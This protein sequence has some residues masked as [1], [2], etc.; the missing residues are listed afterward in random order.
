MLYALVRSGKIVFYICVHRLIYYS[1]PMPLHSCCAGILAATFL[2]CLHEQDFP[3]IYW[4]DKS[5]CS[6]QKDRS[7]KIT[8]KK[9]K[10]SRAGVSTDAFWERTFHVSSFRSN[11]KCTNW[12]RR[13]PLISEP[14]I[15][16]YCG[17]GTKYYGSLLPAVCLRRDVPYFTTWI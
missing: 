9:E 10:E 15:E 7:Q 12:A 14:W 13:P 11:F 16:Q 8:Q 4:W 17:T 1:S 2:N 6:D 5:V 3:N